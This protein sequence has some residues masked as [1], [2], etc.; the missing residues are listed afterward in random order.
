MVNGLFR[1]AFVSSGVKPG[2]RVGSGER[3][4][5]KKA[6]MLIFLFKVVKLGWV[7]RQVLD[8]YG[9]PGPQILQP[10]LEKKYIKRQPGWSAL[11][12]EGEGG[13][14]VCARACERVLSFLP[15]APHTLSCTPKFPFPLPLP[16]PRK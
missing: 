12:G 1:R 16:L 15:H 10:V 3:G 5:L 13:I 6:G 9:L 14:W 7:L 11:K 8:G 4:S 2:G